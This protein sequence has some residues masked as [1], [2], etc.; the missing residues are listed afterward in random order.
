LKAGL[1]G[2]LSAAVFWGIGQK[3]ADMAFLNGFDKSAGFAG[4][5]NTGLTAGQF[6]GQVAAHAAAG[7]VLSVLQGGKF[8]HG[9]VSA[10]VTKALTPAIGKAIGSEGS[11]GYVVRGTIISAVVGGTSSVLSGGKFGNGAATGAFQF[12]FNE[13]ASSKRKLVSYDT[14]QRKGLANAAANRLNAHF[15]K[16]PYLSMDE[17]ANAFYAMGGHVP[18]LFG[19]EIGA[20]FEKLSDGT[21]RIR[22]VTVGYNDCYAPGAKECGVN[23]VNP[24]LSDKFSGDIHIHP[25]NSPW[26][27]IGS[28][29][30]AP[31]SS[32]DVSIWD[33]SRN[34]SRYVFDRHAPLGAGIYRLNLGS[35]SPELKP[36]KV[37]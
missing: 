25:G 27:T 26:D 1:W 22:Q 34:Y 6:A 28:E 24:R 17:A 7:G 23:L 2:A 36:E 9:F 16:L 19:Y 20:H 30:F 29:R 8:G 13:V 32:A 10:G 5:A 37:Q 11:S 3:F 14:E 12:L 33:I 4:F 18:D 31:F 15:A 21:F 35:K